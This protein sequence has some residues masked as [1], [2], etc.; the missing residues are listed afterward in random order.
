[1]LHG[2]GMLILFLRSTGAACHSFIN[3]LVSDFIEWTKQTLLLFLKPW[4]SHRCVSPVNYAHLLAAPLILASIFV[5]V[6]LL[7]ST[8]KPHNYANKLTNGGRVTPPTSCA[9]LSKITFFVNGVW[10]LRREWTPEPVNN[11]P[12]LVQLL[13]NKPN[14]SC[15]VY[16]LRI[17][18]SFYQ[19]SRFL[20]LS[21][22]LLFLLS[23][24]WTMWC[25]CGLSTQ[26]G[27][28]SI[29]WVMLIP[30]VVFS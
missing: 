20:S 5:I 27:V 19:I 11:R 23:T 24:L 12:R 17:C 14:W 26:T 29:R 4:K 9:I 30:P 3:M 25:K 28:V 16:Q 22:Q 6:H 8:P 10:W 18:S 13:L 2:D 15:L 1:M 7:C 21:G